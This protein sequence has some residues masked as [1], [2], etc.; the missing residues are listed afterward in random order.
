MP[1]P[2]AGESRE[3]FLKRCIPAKIDE[4]MDS[5]QA[6]ASCMSIYDNKEP[7]VCPECKGIGRTKKSTSYGSG[8]AVRYDLCY[9]C[10][11]EGII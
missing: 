4:G 1:N 3:D 7:R 8:T 2:S 6:A 11:G 10:R 5:D 9:E